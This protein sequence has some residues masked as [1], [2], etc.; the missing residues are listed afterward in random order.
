MRIQKRVKL[1]MD[2]VNSG[3]KFSRVPSAS[4]GIASV[5][6]RWFDIIIRE[7]NVIP[8]LKDEYVFVVLR[9]QFERNCGKSGADNLLRKA[10]KDYGY[11]IKLRRSEVIVIKYR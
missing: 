8:N 4:V 2:E 1:P 9:S 11:K 3:L 10:L 7:R 6:A 5:L